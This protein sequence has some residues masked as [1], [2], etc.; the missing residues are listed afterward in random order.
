[1][2]RGIFGLKQ[3]ETV[4]GHTTCTLPSIIRMVMSGSMRWAG[5]VACMGRNLMHLRF[6]LE[7]HKSR[8]NYKDLH[9]HARIILKYIIEEQAGVVWIRLFWLRIANSRWLLLTL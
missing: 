4:R 5:H 8:D 3:D 1:M 6:L 2:L 7:S 9:I